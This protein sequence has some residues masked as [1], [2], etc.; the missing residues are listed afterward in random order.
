MF[1]GFSLDLR[2]V[3]GPHCIFIVASLSWHFV[4]YS[5]DVGI[6]VRLQ[7]DLPGMLGSSLDIRLIFFLAFVGSSLD[8]RRP[9]VG[10]SLDL[11]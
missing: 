7:L 9:Y 6:F 4:G 3:F 8:H 5:T 2:W 11:P 1:V 10:S